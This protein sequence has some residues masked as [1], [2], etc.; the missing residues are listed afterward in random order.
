MNQNLMWS[1]EQV[2]EVFEKSREGGTTVKQWTDAAL[3]L[4]YERGFN[5]GFVAGSVGVAAVAVGALLAH[6]QPRITAFVRRKFGRKK[7]TT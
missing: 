4:G 3:N 5:Y 7:A 6:F 1:D 2:N